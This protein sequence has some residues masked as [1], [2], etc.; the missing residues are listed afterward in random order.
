MVDADDL[1]HSRAD[2]TWKALLS[3]REKLVST[4][5]VLVETFALVQRRLGME[6]VQAIQRDVIPV[7]EIMWI[8]RESHRAAMERF[9]ES[10]RRHLSLVDCSS[11]EIMRRQGILSAFTFDSHFS[12][13]GFQ[14]VPG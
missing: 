8:D 2:A 14:Q 6:A 5:Y 1:H 11:F 10:S 7:I 4:N 13:H 12:E 9:L 3:S